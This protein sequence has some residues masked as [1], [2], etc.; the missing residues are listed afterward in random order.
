MRG[1]FHSRPC[2]NAPTCGRPAR[3]NLFA[4]SGF[5]RFCERCRKRADRHGHPQQVPLRTPEVS[6]YAKRIERLLK[7][8]GNWERIETYLRETASLLADVVQDPAYAHPLAADGKT[9]IWVN[10]WRQR[11]KDEVLK[12]LGDSDAV[13]SSIVVAA[14]FLLRDL[15][16]RHFV[17]DRGWEFQLVRLWRSQT[18]LSFG[19]FYNAKSGKTVA[20][21]RDLPPRVVQ[22][23]AL[24][25]VPTYSR[26]AGY[27]VAAFHKNLARQ[28]ALKENLAE[29][30]APLL[31]DR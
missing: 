29:G 12:V 22:E 17:S 15:D 25:L 8:R 20:T 24:L 19:S 18:R 6:K 16:A 31:A 30:F 28:A 4:T 21:Y 5:G 1:S 14:V 7:K 9:G 27:V 10:R 23:L 2:A 26:F 11:A 13:G 3:G